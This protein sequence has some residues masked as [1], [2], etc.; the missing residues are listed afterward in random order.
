[1]VD[2]RIV[3]TGFK[4]WAAV[5]RGIEEGD[6]LCLIRKGKKN[7]EIFDISRRR[8]WLVPTYRHQ[9]EEYIQPFYREYL[10]E[11]Q[12]HQEETGDEY[13]HVQGWVQSKSVIKILKNE[14]LNWLTDYT[15]YS[16]RCL[17]ER[18]Q[19]QPN[20]A[21]H[22]LIVRGYKLNEPRILEA[23]EGVRDCTAQD[24]ERW[25]ELQQRIP[26]APDNPAIPDDEF[27]EK[28]QEFKDRFIREGDDQPEPLLF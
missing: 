13:V 8:F 10:E 1:M 15:V 25:V 11:T 22:A 17:Q 6:Q 20:E 21:L 24:G 9:K 2:P 5:N 19:L 12:E 18:F 14:R 4:E 27:D 28:M 26:M 16:P 7:E 3:L 23:P